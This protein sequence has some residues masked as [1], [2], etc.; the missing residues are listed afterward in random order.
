MQGPD[1]GNSEAFF[2]LNAYTEKAFTFQ[3]AGDA[4]TGIV[5]S[6]DKPASRG[7][8]IIV[9]GPQY[10]AGSHRQFVL[11]ARDLASHGIPCMR[12]DCRG[13]GDSEGEMRNF[14]DID[15]DIQSAVEAFFRQCPGMNEI[16]LWGLCDAATAAIFHAH[17]DSR[18]KG[19]VLLNPWARTAEG[20]A[21]TMVKHY[22][23]SRLTDKAFWKK[24]FSGKLDFRR[25]MK[26]LSGSISDMK[27]QRTEA[28]LP[29]RMR[30]EL[31]KYEGRILLVMSGRDLTA[32]EFDDVAKSWK[33]LHER[34]ERRDLHDADHTFSR[35]AWRNQVSRWTEEWVRSW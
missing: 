6:P 18:V 9:G 10:R 5:S 32:R 28:S 31:E 12:F 8:L 35:R 13:M 30:A 4:L 1:R 34:F 19:L 14:E 16:V 3:C 2:E 20:Q 17:K 27:G 22:Y 15:E 24:L 7:V 26:D 21:K 29:E 25:S 33:N 11:L 23:F